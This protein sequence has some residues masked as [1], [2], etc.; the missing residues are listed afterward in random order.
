MKQQ[1][2]PSVGVVVEEPTTRA[3]TDLITPEKA[4]QLLEECKY[5]GQ[6]SLD[7]GHVDELA[8][9]MRLGLFTVNT[10]MLARFGNADYLI[11]GQHTLWAIVESQMS[12]F[13]PIVICD[14]P[15]WDDVALLYVTTDN[16]KFRKPQEGFKPYDMTQRLDLNEWQLRSL[17]AALRIIEEDFVPGRTRKGVWMM[18]DMMAQWS[19]HM[20][21]YINATKTSQFARRFMRR[22][23]AATGIATFADAYEK[24]SDFW[25][26]VAVD[27]G[28]R[29]GDPRKVLHR[30]IIQTSIQGGTAMGGLTTEYALR[31]IASCW[32]AWFEEREMKRYRVDAG[33][34]VELAGT[35]WA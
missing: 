12:L 20:H 24:A 8:E 31:V 25:T 4:L 16:G 35:R 22:D 3:T 14:C 19:P 30:F 6:R 17:Y 10:I 21:N 23:L 34:P 2:G 33:K 18:K 9:Q 15:A 1:K 27:D 7:Q 26:Q 28:L 29:V 11:N 32:N 13:L 5:E